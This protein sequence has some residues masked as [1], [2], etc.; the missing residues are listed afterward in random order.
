M[1]RFSGSGPS[2]DDLPTTLAQ[3]KEEKPGK[4]KEVVLDMPSSSFVVH[5][6]R[7]TAAELSFIEKLLKASELSWDEKVDHVVSLFPDVNGRPRDLDAKL[8]EYHDGDTKEALITL[9]WA[10]KNNSARSLR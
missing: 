7:P 4:S 10:V 2:L 5:R 1:Q 9:L 6:D 8:L 3:P